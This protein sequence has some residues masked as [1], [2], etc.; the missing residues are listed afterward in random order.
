MVFYWI[1]PMCVVC[2][3]PLKRKGQGFG[4]IRISSLL[5]CKLSGGH[6]ALNPSH[7]GVHNLRTISGL[8]ATHVIYGQPPMNPDH[9]TGVRS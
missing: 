7:P 6:L 9:V 8:L 4:F 1:F 2:L 5:G 3:P